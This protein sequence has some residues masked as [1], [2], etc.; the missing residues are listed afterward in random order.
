LARVVPWI[1]LGAAGKWSAVATIINLAKAAGAAIE[2]A[3]EST[4]Q[5]LARG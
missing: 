3:P 2:T 5:G 4:G 1:G